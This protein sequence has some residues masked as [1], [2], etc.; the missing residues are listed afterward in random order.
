MALGSGLERSQC[1]LDEED[2]VLNVRSVVRIS[3]LRCIER[4]AKTWIQAFNI[5]N[6]CIRGIVVVFFLNGKQFG[7]Q[8]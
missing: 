6:L 3:V 5:A 2:M 7:F 8:V 4:V 1:L